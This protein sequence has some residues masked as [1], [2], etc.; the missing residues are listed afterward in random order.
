MSCSLVQHYQCFGGIF[1]LHLPGRKGPSL[2]KMG[3]VYG[4]KIFVIITRLHGVTVQ[5]RVMFIV[6]TWRTSDLIRTSMQ[7]EMDKRS[8]FPQIANK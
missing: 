3:M 8:Y 4:S 6:T 7:V 5:K 1:C 2:L